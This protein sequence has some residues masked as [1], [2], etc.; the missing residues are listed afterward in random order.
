MLKYVAIM[1]VDRPKLWSNWSTGGIKSYQYF[2]SPI[3][4]ERD[5]VEKWLNDEKKKYPDSR[6]NEEIAD[7]A[8]IIDTTIIAFDDQESE[9]IEKFLEKIRF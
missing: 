6:I 8:F 4:T 9:N 3:E 2:K 1:K 5:K 7:R